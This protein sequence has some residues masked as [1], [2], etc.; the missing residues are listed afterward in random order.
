[1]TL[2]ARAGLKQCLLP[3]LLLLACNKT[4]EVVPA[5]PAPAWQR[6]AVVDFHA[7]LSL[8]GLERIRQ[9]QADNGIALMI[10]LSGGSARQG[11]EAWQA[12]KLLADQLPGRIVNFESPNWRGFGQ[13]GWAQREA[14][15][16]EHAVLHF[17]F[18]GLKIAKGLGL[19]HTDQRDQLVAA[20]DPRI[21]PLWDKAGELGVPVCI[22]VADPRAFWWPLTRQNERWDELGVHPYWA[23]GPVPAEVLATFPTE[24]Q[25]LV[26]QRPKV[27][28]WP[29]MLQAA[30]RMYRAHPRTS[31]VAVH[32]GNAAEDLDYVD[33][34]LQRN[35]N[36]WIDTAAR[37]GE[38]GRHPAEKV[39]AFFEKWQDR[40]VFGTD[41]GIGSDYLMLGSNGEIEPQLADIKPFYQAHWQYFETTAKQ[42]AH[43]SPIQGRWR[44]DAIGL[45][46]PVL[47]KI[48]RLN[49]QSL[50]DR[51]A[52]K[53]HG[54]QVQPATGPVP[55]P[56]D[57]TPVWAQPALHR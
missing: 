2:L 14:A 54:A 6:G 22:H 38:F 44:V 45:P 16:L 1:M 30:E 3:L 24:V 50:L 39:R 20:D 21:G 35:A 28:S 52:R 34:L 33:G 40:I 4:A 26:V 18:K 41:I 43:P 57:P 46:T 31:F 11:T 23:Y 29:E 8:D 51:A 47:D 10:N 12:A 49:A 13:P 27:P 7:H 36:V 19:G 9:V 53:A 37:V 5:K 17:D 25:E 32:F 48:Y 56:T 15:A 42:I 55:P